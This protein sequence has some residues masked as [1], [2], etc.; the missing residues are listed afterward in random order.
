MS[1]N[2]TLA[3][4]LS[5]IQNAELLG[6]REC[7]IR[8]VS[9]VIKNVLDILRQNLYVG[10]YTEIKDGQGT[11]LRLNLLGNINRCNAIKPRS[12]VQLHNYEKLEKRFLPA[13]DFGIIIVSTS[14]G[15]MTHKE[16]KEQ[17]LGGR[18][19]SYCY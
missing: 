16:A 4:A 8:H 5:V 3:M 10:D 11:Y 17:G 18:V 2:D 9:K 7:H 15:M 13:K 19:L 6:K 1:M 12:A 14:R